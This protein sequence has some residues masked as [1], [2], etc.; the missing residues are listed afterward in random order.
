ML[1]DFAEDGAITYVFSRLGRA[2][3]DRDGM[4]ALR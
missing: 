4:T 2:Q 3:P 1:D